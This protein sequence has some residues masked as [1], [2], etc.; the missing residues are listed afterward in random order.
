MGHALRVH[1]DRSRPLQGGQRFARPPGRRPLARPR[2]RTARAADDRQRDDRPARRRRI[3]GRGARRDR[4]RR[5]STS[6]R[7]R[8]STRCRGPT[9]S[10]QHTLYIGA[11][12]GIA[13]GP[14]DGRTAEMLIR[15]ADLALYRSKD[16]GGGAFHTYEPQLHVKAEERRVLEMAL[17]QALEKGEMHLEYQPVVDAGTGSLTGFEALLRWTHPELG[18]VSPGQ[19]RA[20]RRGRAADRADRRMG[21]ALGLR[22]GRALA[23]ADPR[24]GQRLARTAAQSRP[25][26]SVVASALANSGLPRRAARARS[27]RGRVHARRHRRGA[28][29]RTHPR[30][31]RAAEPRRFRHRLFVARLSRAHALLDD[32]GRPQ[33]RPGRVQGPARADRDH[34]RR[35]R[36]RRS[37]SAWRRPPKA[38]RP[39]RSIR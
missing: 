10:T 20:A 4:Q 14:R 27:D 1:D 19:V 11:S 22:R 3:R 28:G 23:R 37:R 35:R 18:V 7:R 12:V 5:A 34:P 24:R 29:A 31:R 8:S 9:R 15:S 6:W 39:S 38:S 32:Q 17:R 33:L 26:S 36:A 13:I 16:A 30:S 25:S 21:A 2:V